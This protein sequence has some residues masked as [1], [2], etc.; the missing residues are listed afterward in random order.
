MKPGG[1]IVV[2][3]DAN[4]KTLL[5]KHF[6]SMLL[7]ML[8][9]RVNWKEAKHPLLLKTQFLCLQYMLLGCANEETIVEHSKSMVFLCFSN[10]S[11]FAEPRNTY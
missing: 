8:P 4:E 7:T 9:R 3:A 11:S 1:K 5:Q 6:E 10:A 2:K